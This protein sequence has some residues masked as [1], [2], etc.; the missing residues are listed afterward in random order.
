MARY[1]VLLV[2]GVLYFKKGNLIICCIFNAFLVTTTVCRRLQNANYVFRWLYFYTMLKTKSTN[3]ENSGTEDKETQTV[4]TENDSEVSTNEQRIDEELKKEERKREKGLKR[5]SPP[6]RR[7]YFRL[8]ASSWRDV[9][10]C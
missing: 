6:E 3:T 9:V 8:H 7:H 5:V 4:Q 2:Y 1:V 10:W